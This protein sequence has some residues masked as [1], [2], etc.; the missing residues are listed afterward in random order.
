MFLNFFLDYLH[1]FTLYDNVGDLTR[2]E[3]PTNPQGLPTTE[4]L[5]IVLR[6]AQRLLSDYAISSLSV[7]TISI[8]I[9]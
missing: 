2:V 5:S 6:H 9:S 4:S 1:F 8:F 3:L 7:R